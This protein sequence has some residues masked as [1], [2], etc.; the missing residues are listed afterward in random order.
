VLQA[1]AKTG[2]GLD[3]ETELKLLRV[4][5]SATDKHPVQLSVTFLPAHAVP[6]NSTAAEATNEIVNSQL[7]ALKELVDKKEVRCDS[8]DVFCETGVFERAD[9]EKILLA[10]K[11]IMNL[12]GN[13][14]GDELTWCGSGEL[15]EVVGARA[16]SH[17]EYIT[18]EG[19][20]A[21]QRAG[22]VAVLLP[23]TA[24]ILHLTPPPARDIING[25]VPVAIASDFN[26]NAH[27]LAMPMVMNLACV[28]MRLSMEEVLVGATIN[29]ARALG[30]EDSYGSIE[31]GK[32]G[33]FVVLDAPRWEHLIYQV[34]DPPLEQVIVKGKVVIESGKKKL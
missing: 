26:P 18:K 5:S 22:S 10:A 28:Q 24:Q 6:A 32:V 17:L 23:T 33:S 13:Y 12:P 3:W 19:I 34:G 11:Q 27:C 21:M 2:Y 14:H 7:P 16:V 9:T 25:N 30:L 15:A 4:L 20:D 8:V 29:A 1:E 31:K